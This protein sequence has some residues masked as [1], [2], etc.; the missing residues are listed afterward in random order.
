M[1]NCELPVWP[2]GAGEEEAG[3]GSKDLTQWLLS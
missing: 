1:T 3:Q 2:S